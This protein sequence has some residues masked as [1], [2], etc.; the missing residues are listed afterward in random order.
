MM[1]KLASL[2]D[3]YY[4]S[5][6]PDLKFLE[7]ERLRIVAKLKKTIFILLPLGLGASFLFIQTQLFIPLH[8][9]I[10]SGIMG[11]LIY[12]FVYRNESAGYKSLFKDQIIEKVIHFIDSS[13]VYSKNDSILEGEY[14][15]SQIFPQSYDRYSGN[16]LV[17]GT[18]DSVNVRFS[19][20]HVEEK[21]RDKDGK[22]H[23]HTIFQGLFF[24]ADFNK[25][26][27]GKTVVLPDVAQRS[28]G[29]I[30]EWMQS[31]NTS[32]GELI[33][34]DHSEFEK[35]FVVYG[36]DQI[37]SR[38]ILSHALMEKIVVFYKKNGKNI[39]IS[40]RDSKMYL[41]IDYKKELFEPILSKS[42]L[43]FS[44]IREY[45]E[46]LSMIVGIV[47][48]FKLNEKIWAKQ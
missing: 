38:Y 41:C 18:I 43:K 45:F 31:I 1:A 10:I 25:N 40:F 4:E 8:A 22:E 24:I 3:Y 28:L 19:D 7:N 37:E 12:M 17:Q 46:L 48:E 29:I 2:M 30:G 44:Y 23:W 36:S 26:F 16:D 9:F 27:R 32:R 13:L 39:A 5:M 47:S 14:Q 15:Y 35:Y 34:L 6:Y 11:F 33:K 42:L 21:Q 20:L